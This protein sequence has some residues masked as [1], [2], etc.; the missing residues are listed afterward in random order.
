[1][2]TKKFNFSVRAKV[3]A[4]IMILSQWL[5]LPI[6]KVL[7]MFYNSVTYELLNDRSTMLWSES[8]FY[9]ADEFLLEKGI[10]L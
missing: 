9:I 5:N 2:D 6:A 10:K 1:M 3:T 4:A 7:N 8:P